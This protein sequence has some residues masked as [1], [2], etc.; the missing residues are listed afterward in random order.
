M[1]ERLQGA[2]EPHHEGV[3]RIDEALHLV[4]Y[5]LANRVEIVGAA[6]GD[7]LAETVERPERQRHRHPNDDRGADDHEQQA[8]RGADQDRM[9]QLLAGDGGFRHGHRKRHGIDARGSGAGKGSDADRLATERGVLERRRLTLAAGDRRQ[10]LIAG[11]EFSGRPVGAVE[12]AVLRCGRQHFQSHIGDIDLER[13]VLC[14]DHPLGDR[15]RGAGQHAV[16]HV[17]CR[18]DRLVPGVDH[19]DRADHRRRDEKP[20]KQ[21]PAQGIGRRRRQWLG[22]LQERRHGAGAVVSR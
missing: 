13:P 1:P 5:P 9:R 3:D 8:Q 11:D 12:D 16:G 6:F 20:G 14:N 17:V 10:R 15:Q 7:R 19:G 21:P 18:I 22:A 2:F 4:R